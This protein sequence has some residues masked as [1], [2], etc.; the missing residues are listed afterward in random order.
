[1]PYLSELYLQHGGN[2]KAGVVMWH[3]REY[4]CVHA[5]NLTNVCFTSGRIFKYLAHM[6]KMH[7]V[8][9][10]GKEAL[11]EVKESLQKFHFYKV[12][13]LGKSRFFVQHL[14]SQCTRHTVPLSHTLIF[15]YRTLPLNLVFGF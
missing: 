11:D 5:L 15:S 2:H 3:T 6:T 1:M 12:P 10:V 14:R 9:H 8:H 4:E 13:W 7:R